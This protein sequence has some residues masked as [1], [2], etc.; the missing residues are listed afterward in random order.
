MVG[1]VFDLQT[2]W[3]DTSPLW[4]SAFSR[5][6]PLTERPL[7]WSKCQHMI[8]FSSVQAFSWTVSSK[9]RRASSRSIWRTTCLTSTHRSFDVYGFAD[10]WRVILSWLTS[11]PASP[12]S[13]SISQT[14]CCKSGSPCITLFFL[15]PS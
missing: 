11:P 12:I 3:I 5:L 7:Q 6:M 13:P 2:F 8:S 10:K 14:R 15:Y 9:I 4:Y 1:F